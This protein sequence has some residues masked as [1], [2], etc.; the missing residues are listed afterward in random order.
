MKKLSI[1]GHN[2]KSSDEFTKLG[3]FDKNPD[4]NTSDASLSLKTHEI[5]L[6]I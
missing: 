2:T 5:D 3:K 6:K 4:V 1:N